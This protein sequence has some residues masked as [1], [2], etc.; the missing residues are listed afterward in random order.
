MIETSPS[1]HAFEP[2]RDRGPTAEP[3][4]GVE[5][6]LVSLPYASLS[7]PSLALGLLAATLDRGGVA[8]ATQ[9][10]NLDFAATVGLSKYQL[11]A[12]QAP[13]DLL[14]GE[15]TFA[16]AAFGDAAPEPEPYLERIARVHHRIGG[17]HRSAREAELLVVALCELRTAAEVWLDAAVERAL[18]TGASLV[19][20]TSTFE[21]HTA[22]L[23]FLRRV[24]ARAPEV[25]TLLGGANCEGAMGAAT[26]RAFEWVDVVVSGEA[27][28]LVVDLCR[29]LL[30]Q[31]RTVDPRRLPPGVL[32]P[33]HRA[34]NGSASLGRA[35]V[36]DLDAQAI[37]DFR[38]YFAE[39]A[40]S[41]LSAAI[42]P[43]LPIETS[44]GC[45]WG[46]V[47]HC[48]FCGLNG[49]SMAFRS[50]SP[51][52]V[53]REISELEERH[54][55][56]RF[57]AVDNILDMKY[58]QELI[59][60]L[61]TDGRPR[62][63]FYEVK[64]NLRRNQLES[65]A[66][67]GIRHLQPG[68]ESLHSDELRLMAKGVSGWQN[69][70]LLR[71][72]RELGIRL[73]WNY[74]WGFP[75]EDDAWYAE[76][77]AWLPWIE[78]LE[79]PGSA[80]RVRFDRFSPYFARSAEWQLELEPM[81]T[82]AHIYPL[83]EED[84]REL[85][86]YFA[87]RGR[88]ESFAVGNSDLGDLMRGRPG[89]QALSACIQPWNRSWYLRQAVLSFEER[90]GALHFVDRRAVASAPTFTLS[91]LDAVVYRACE[92]APKAEQLPMIIAAKLGAAPLEDELAHVRETLAARRL[93]LAIDERLVAL[94]IE[95]PSHRLPAM[96]RAA[97]F[98]GGWVDLSLP[99]RVGTAN[100]D[101]STS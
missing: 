82:Y 31:G 81:P 78:H 48:T 26:H 92:D 14:L 77:A 53:R 63:L 35:L 17:Y 32:A 37:P 59:P 43:G 94:A 64:S 2:R 71:H 12:Q 88:P 50:K 49:S 90:E 29:T 39:L 5:V 74:L 9:H 52:R 27:D 80:V 7:R 56:S 83:P 24:R 54:G 100:G 57:E 65:L 13:K 69:L 67:A 101:G 96:P 75:D 61:A 23:A 62:S 98:P 1:S 97:D 60:A 70:L 79:P 25:V 91:G 72:A 55:F 45:W 85:A 10:A 28:E 16:R 66:A 86:Y 30:E 18:A 87:A 73:I 3:R 4:E 99:P 84:L 68:I 6:C 76:V 46:A 89:V 95:A 51:E 41:P 34:Q 38:G 36:R 44:R 58:F 42:H 21:Q 33:A 93:V 20:C 22:S 8:T 11:C 40:T 19:G 15:W 47:S